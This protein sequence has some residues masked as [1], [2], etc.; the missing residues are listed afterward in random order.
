[1]TYVIASFGLQTAAARFL[2]LLNESETELWSA[3]SAIFILTLVVTTIATIAFVVLS[4]TLSVYFTKTT[5]WTFAFILGAFWVFSG[6]LAL[7]F[8]AFVQGLRRYKSIATILLVSRLALIGFTF[9]GLYFFDS[10]ET[11]ILA[12]IIYNTIVVGWSLGI[13]GK[14]I[15]N[16][17]GKT[18]IRKI[19]RYSIPLG[20][21][22]MVGVI[23]N[24]ID[25]FLVGGYLNALALGVYNAAV[26]MSGALSLVLF[27]PLVTALLP[28]F[29]ARVDNESEIASGLR[30]AIRF[31][32]LAT[33]PS[34]FIL[35]G[36][37]GQALEI[38]AGNR[39]YLSGI[40][41]LQILCLLF[42]IGSIQ[43]VFTSLLQALG[44]TLLIM[45]IGLLSVLTVTV[46]SVLL[47]PI[48][49]ITGAALGNALLGVSGIGIPLIF[50]R[51]Y[52]R[53]VGQFGFY[54]KVL[55]SSLLSFVT[56][57]ELANRISSSPFTILPYT[58]IGT[59]IFLILLR[60]FR[61][62]NAEDKKHLKN[63]LPISLQRLI[64]LL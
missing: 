63:F 21:A 10:V 62:L 14:R 53:G 13:T 7:V 11:P 4:P 52:V 61:T 27:T 12:W 33:L 48:Y 1:V 49:G 2:A 59:G 15:L 34:S 8:Q 35:A 26:V 44:R 20:F 41:A 32:I 3:A 6:T 30:L 54:S 19:L 56:M 60:A 64:S 37:S 36:V 57:S 9:F 25:Q 45:I 39:V 42:V 22:A 16:F 47:I 17:R 40:T 38:F 46:I 28:E 23:A 51:K 58:V 24:T 31:V 18:E 55:V 5:E 50:T 43:G 29:S